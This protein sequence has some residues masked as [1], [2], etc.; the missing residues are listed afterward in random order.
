MSTQEAFLLTS[1]EH[2]C[3]S[4]VMEEIDAFLAE[5]ASQQTNHLLAL[6]NIVANDLEK[7]RAPETIEKVIR[8]IREELGQ[9]SF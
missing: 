8:L 3:D 5:L 2:S 9:E 7:N 4:V 1:E 6:L